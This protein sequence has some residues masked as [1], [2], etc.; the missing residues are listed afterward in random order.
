MED[1][2]IAATAYESNLTVVT[3]NTKHFAPFLG[4]RVVDWLGPSHR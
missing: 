4:V 2:L 3:A 1:G